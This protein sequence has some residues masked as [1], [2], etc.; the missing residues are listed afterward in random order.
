M[1][2]YS[3]FIYRWT[4]MVNNKMYIGS[5]QGNIDD[6]YIGSGVAFKWAVRKYGVDNFSREILEYIP[7]IGM[8]RDREQYWLDLN[9]CHTNPMYY[10]ISQNSIG[11][12][13]IEAMNNHK[14]WKESDPTRYSDRQKKASHS[15]NGINNPSHPKFGG[16][17]NN[18]EALEIARIKV[19]DRMNTP[20]MIE[21][22]TQWGKLMSD[23]SHPMSVNNINNPNYYKGRLKATDPNNP[24][25]IN[26]PTHP[27]YG[28]G[29]ATANA[30][31]RTNADK[32]TFIN[33]ET[34]TIEYDI[35]A[36]DMA[37]KYHLSAPH[38]LRLVGRKELTSYK[39]WRLHN[40]Q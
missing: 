23:P 3:G 39:N 12:T 14:K 22:Q 10:N 13:S 31:R 5:H 4:N 33:T 16:F 26:N 40:E 35:S 15:P 18:L 36:L 21:K 34:G 24:N 7:E 37:S 32:Y 20:V 6:G 28:K 19:R 27:S 11:F 1:V 38:Y 25:S 29:A 2:N 9:Q 8:I 30:N 17:R